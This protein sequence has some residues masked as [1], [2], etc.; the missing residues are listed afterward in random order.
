MRRLGLY[1]RARQVAA[2]A[3]VALACVAGTGALAGDAPPVRTMLAVFALA[4]VASATATGLAG[5]DPALDRTAALDWRWRRVAHVVAAGA[6]AAGAVTALGVV[7]DPLVDGAVVVRDAVGLTG[8]AALGVVLLGG[9][10]AWCVPTVWAV[11]A[12]SA[13]LVTPSPGAPLVTWLV[14]PPGTTAATVTAGVLGVLGTA[15]YAV[16]GPPAR[17]G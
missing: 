10:L 14:Q 8:L 2:G 3:A 11:V 7:T 16:L 1:L 12:V 15:V 6:L 17:A 13:L 4:L 5:Q 9:G